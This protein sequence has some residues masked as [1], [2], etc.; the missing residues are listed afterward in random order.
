MRNLRHDEILEALQ[1]MD[2]TLPLETVQHDGIDI[3]E[4]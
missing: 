3:T 1:S 2:I 4:E